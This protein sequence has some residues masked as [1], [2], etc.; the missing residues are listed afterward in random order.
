MLSRRRLIQGAAILPLAPSFATT[1]SERAAAAPVGAPSRVRPGDPGWPSSSEWERLR[2]RVE[3]RLIKVQSPLGACRAP[4]GEAC[5][6]S[7]GS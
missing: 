6:E 3:G 1:G 5:R 4:D 2:Q 7:S